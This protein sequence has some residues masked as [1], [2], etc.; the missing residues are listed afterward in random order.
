MDVLQVRPSN[1]S[2]GDVL[3][4]LDTLLIGLSTISI[5]SYLTQPMLLTSPF[6]NPPAMVRYTVRKCGFRMPLCK[7]PVD[8]VI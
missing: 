6:S 3:L 7:S 8:P 5:A 2:S 1:V 4:W